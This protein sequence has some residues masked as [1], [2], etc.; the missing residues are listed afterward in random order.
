MWFDDQEMPITK[1]GEPLFPTPMETK[2]FHHPRIPGIQQ[3]DKIKVFISIGKKPILTKEELK[4]QKERFFEKYRKQA[5]RSEN[6]LN[7]LPI[8][9]S[10]K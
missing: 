6:N 5:I 9:N 8:A 4:A 1:F 7:K 3:P 2:K 10:E